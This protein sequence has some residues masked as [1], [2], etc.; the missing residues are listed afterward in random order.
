MSWR[1]NNLSWNFREFIIENFDDFV[2]LVYYLYYYFVLRK[3]I[4][5]LL[6]LTTT[7]WNF[8]ILLNVFETFSYFKGGQKKSV[9]AKYNPII[10]FW[11]FF[12]YFVTYFLSFLIVLLNIKHIGSWKSF[13]NISFFSYY[14]SSI[15]YQIHKTLFI[16]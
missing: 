3:C 15:L 2:I 10:L 5:N 16:K 14:F 9:F 11:L 13:T 8:Y 7:I 1:P 12:I 6:I 4:E